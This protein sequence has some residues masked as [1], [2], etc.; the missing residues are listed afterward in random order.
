[1]SFIETIEAMIKSIIALIVIL[2][3]S[4]PSFSQT[5]QSPSC[6]HDEYTF[7]CVQYVKNYDADTITF[8]IPGVH[9]L[10]GKSISVRVRGVDTAEIRGSGVCE[11]KKAR[12]AKRLVENLMKNAKSIELRQVSKDKYFRILADVYYDQKSLKDIL[13]KNHL[14]YA[15]EGGKKLRPNWCERIP[16]SG[17]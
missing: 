3:S 2:S 17:L 5:L 7:R 4:N 9:P 16:A 11:M 10:I 15:Y 6:Q 12:I 8:N 1:M 14:A 13:F